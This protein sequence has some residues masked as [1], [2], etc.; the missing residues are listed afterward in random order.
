MPL[1]RPCRWCLATSLLSS[2]KHEKTHFSGSIEA[3]SCNAFFFCRFGFIGAPLAISVTYWNLFILLA[4]Y[5]W[6]AGP[7]YGW[8]G[9]SRIVFE[10]LGLNVR[11]GT[12]GILSVASEEYGNLLW[13]LPTRVCLLISFC[14]AQIRLGSYE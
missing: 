13:L 12:A 9:L 1:R 14:W 2:G 8:A 11:Y 6:V 10:D 3:Q 7:R 5:T 4:L